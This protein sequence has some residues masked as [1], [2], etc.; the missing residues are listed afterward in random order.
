MVELYS[1]EGNNLPNG[2]ISLH[3]AFLNSS[4]HHCL[5][6]TGYFIGCAGVHFTLATLKSI[7]R[8]AKNTDASELS[9]VRYSDYIV[10]ADT[11]NR[12]SK[13]LHVSETG[14]IS[15]KHLA[16]LREIVDS[17]LASTFDDR[18]IN[19]MDYVTSPEALYAAYPLPPPPR[20]KTESYAPQFL[21]IQ[22]ISNEVFATTDKIKNDIDD[23]VLRVC[24][25]IFV[26]AAAGMILIYAIVFFVSR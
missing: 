23:E 12:A 7:L 22:K 19:R 1:I 9:I 6:R 18:G 11:L 2:V 26:I 8:K 5:H 13:P 24:L 21:V 4:R 20:N 3:F 10:L 16:E 15:E 17:S 25:I 14:L